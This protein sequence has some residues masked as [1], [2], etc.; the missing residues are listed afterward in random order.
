MQPCKPF[1]RRMAYD[2]GKQAIIITVYNYVKCGVGGYRAEPA[3]V[4]EDYTGNVCGCNK[5][6]HGATR[7][8]RKA[9]GAMDM[10]SV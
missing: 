8:C 9:F 5:L 7:N 3:V 6:T 2:C 4:A 1:G 10:L